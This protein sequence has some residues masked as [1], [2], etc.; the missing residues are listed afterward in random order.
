MSLSLIMSVLPFSPEKKIS[1]TI[2][3][4]SEGFLSIEVKVHEAETNFKTPPSSSFS[5]NCEI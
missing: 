5:E 1:Q 2:S 4:K 3:S